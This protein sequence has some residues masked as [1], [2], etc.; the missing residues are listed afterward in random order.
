MPRRTV[1]TPLP[2]LER[3]S[4][5]TATRGARVFSAEE[6]GSVVRWRRTQRGTPL[7]KMA[8]S[9]GVGADLLGDLERGT[10]G[11]R[12]E[13]ALVVLARLGFDVV[14]VPRDPGL[15]LHPSAG[16]PA[17]KSFL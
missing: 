16:T 9:L 15:T 11:V 17:D 7:R 10:G 8:A 2:L 13:R 6:L 14:L 1:P 3:P 4:R 5:D 12:L